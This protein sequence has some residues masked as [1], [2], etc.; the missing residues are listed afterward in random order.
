MRNAAVVGGCLWNVFHRPAR[1]WN[2]WLW[3]N[4]P[5]LPPA[6]GTPRVNP[7]PV[8]TT[9]SFSFIY[10]RLTSIQA[11]FCLFSDEILTTNWFFFFQV[12]SYPVGWLLDAVNWCASNQLR[13][14]TAKNAADNYELDANEETCRLLSRLIQ[15]PAIGSY[16]IGCLNYK[17]ERRIGNFRPIPDAPAVWRIDQIHL[18]LIENDFFCW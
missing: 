7:K 10:L 16:Q 14:L 8:T 4:R 15:L 2:W 11:R 13:R 1:C 5:G 12:S 3:P 6:L 18:E 9:F 17:L